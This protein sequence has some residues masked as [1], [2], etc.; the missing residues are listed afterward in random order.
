M[1]SLKSLISHAE[2][3]DRKNDNKG[4]TL[5]PFIMMV[6]LLILCFI[7]SYIVPAGSYERASTQDGTTML[8]DPESFVYIQR[9]PVSPEQLLLSITQ[10]LQRGA[11]IIFFLLIIGGMF[12]VLNTTAAINVGIANILKRLNKR[13]Y[14]I[15]PFLMILFGCGASFCG[16]FEEFL[17]FVPLILAICITIGYDSLTAVGIIFLSA[18]AGYGGAITNSFTLGTAQEIAG[19]ERFSGAELRIVLFITL[20]LSTI[21]YILW[22]ARLVKKSPKF[23]GAYEYDFKYNQSKKLNLEKVAPLSAR[24]TLVL[25]IFLA[26]IIFSIWGIIVQGFYIDELSAVFLIIGILGGFVGGLKPGEICAG[27][28]KGARDMLLPGIMIGL[29]N[30]III[31]LQEANIMDSFL[32]AQ[33]VGLEKLPGGLIAC[34]MFV[35]HSLFNVLV[36]S[37]YTQAVTTMPIMIPIADAVGITR[38]TAVLAYQLG[39]AFTN[40]LAPTGGEILAA[41]AI[42]RVPYG[43]W[44]RFMLPI[45]VIWCV[46][47][48]IF[49]MYASQ[50]AYGPM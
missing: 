32:H 30:S 22:Y 45:F 7:I 23:S 3:K 13:E 20:M 29:A 33:A 49:I 12:S 31:V 44:V 2:N 14:L 47:A 5:H 34:G 38:Q 11:S 15:I 10:G 39:D 43:K 8:V 6:I 17:V 46:I 50:T 1:S 4:K 42:C 19:L 37:G 25:L 16:N 41:L 27:F 28:E 18:A 48:L 40:V 36:P 21:I 26:G 35:M 9:T 24:Q